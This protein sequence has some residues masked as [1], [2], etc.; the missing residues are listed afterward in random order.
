MEFSGVCS[1]SAQ[2]ITSPTENGGAEIRSVGLKQY[3]G[4]KYGKLREIFEGPLVG[5]I[6][7]NT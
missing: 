7:H 1:E 2:T 4:R 3:R 6:L 5:E